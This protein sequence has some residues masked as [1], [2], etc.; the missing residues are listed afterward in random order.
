MNL[1][2][3]L[4]YR[5]KCPFCDDKLSFIFHSKK[6]QASVEDGDDVKIIFDLKSIKKGQRNY[7]V[8]FV[9]NRH[10]NSFYI[11]FYS[12]DMVPFDNQV[13]AF[14]IKRFK[15]FSDNHQ[16][17]KFY[18][19][20][21]NCAHY[22]FQSQYFELDYA[23]QS[24]DEINIEME[25]FTFIQIEDNQRTITS[26]SNCYQDNETWIRRGKNDIKERESLID[27][28]NPIGVS[29][30]PFVSK[31]DTLNRLNTLLTFS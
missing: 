7:K 3:F 4:D 27:F 25:N 10:T 29:I 2:K 1:H 21:D 19:Y 17:F 26:M 16:S 11:E 6:K 13:P 5:S 18:K 22:N 31:E 9:I 23:T 30:I 20:C 12:K 24:I 8:E 28:G 15:D 14:L